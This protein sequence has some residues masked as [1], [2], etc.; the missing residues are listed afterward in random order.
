MARR[1]K[2]EAS[3]TNEIQH[4]KKRAF[5]AAYAE[6]GTITQAAEIANIDRCTHYEWI[7]TDPIYAKAFEVAHQKSIERLEQEARRRAVEGVEEPVYQGGKKVGVV[8]KYSDT[9]LIFLLKGAAPDK[10]RE[11]VQTEHT[12]RID[13]NM[14]VTHDLR[15]LSAAEL[16]QLEAI[17]SKTQE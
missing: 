8:R 5:L 9:L 14:T 4:A 16:A 12:G 7:K 10:Y 3:V 15:K 6:C 13:S 17:L 2:A 11:R 1:K